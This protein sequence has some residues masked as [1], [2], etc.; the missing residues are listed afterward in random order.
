MP[1]DTAY[2]N[3][4]IGN[5]NWDFVSYMKVNHN[6]MR[7]ITIE[8]I[9]YRMD[10]RRHKF[11]PPT[12]PS[13][14]DMY[15]WEIDN[16]CVPGDITYGNAITPEEGLPQCHTYGPSTTVEDRRII[17]VA[18]LNCGE[19][20]DSGRRMNGRTGPLPVETFVKVFLTEPMGKGKDNTIYGEVVGPLIQGQD[21]AV[22]DKVAL[23][24]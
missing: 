4:R 14:Y 7:Q 13:R 9:T 15:R 3:G 8:G 6:Y 2:E 19:I 16:N 17:N 24:R 12:P 11:Y 20:E 18:V 21:E 5:G 1:R 22:N 23:A 10:Y